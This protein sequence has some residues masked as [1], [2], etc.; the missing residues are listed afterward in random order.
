MKRNTKIYLGLF[1]SLGAFIS[2]VNVGDALASWL[3]S[4]EPLKVS[5]FLWYL[6]SLILT[7]YGS[8]RLLSREK[9]E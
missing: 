9:I 4:S 8:Y 5:Y 3:L 2:A 1:T 7:F 6:T